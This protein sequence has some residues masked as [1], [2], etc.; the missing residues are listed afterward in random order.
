[1]PADITMIRKENVFMFFLKPC[2]NGLYLNRWRVYPSEI[3]F[4]L[5]K[6]FL[7]RNKII[8]LNCKI[9]VFMSQLNSI[10]YISVMYQTTHINFTLKWHSTLLESKCVFNNCVNW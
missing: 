5:C 6:I 4:C 7:V 2:L 8:L 10:N 9:Y 3:I 1:M